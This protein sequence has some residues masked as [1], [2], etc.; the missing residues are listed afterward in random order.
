MQSP[1]EQA[2]LIAAELAQ[3]VR[4]TLRMLGDGELTELLC[5]PSPRISIP[6]VSHGDQKCR[7][8]GSTVMTS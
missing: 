3:H 6:I 2:G 7:A 8:S 5:A 4:A 1:V